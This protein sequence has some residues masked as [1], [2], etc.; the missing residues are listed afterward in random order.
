MRNVRRGQELQAMTTGVKYLTVGHRPRWPIG[1]VVNHHHGADGATFSHSLRAPHSSDSKWLNPIQRSFAGSKTDATASNVVENIFF[2]PV[3]I[4][5]GSS[6]LMRNW[7][8]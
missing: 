3:C 5:N 7:L 2:K 6:S 8:N 1:K 4:R